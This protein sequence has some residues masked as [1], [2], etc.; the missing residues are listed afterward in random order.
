MLKIK[1]EDFGKDS[2]LLFE[3]RIY[4]HLEKEEDYILIL[5][6]RKIIQK[7]RERALDKFGVIGDLYLYTFEDLIERTNKQS[8]IGMYFVDIILKRSIEN[9]QNQKK[10][11]KESLY[12]SKGFLVICKQILSLL[13]NSNA[14]IKSLEKSIDL[15][16]LKTILKILAEYEL[17]MKKYNIPTPTELPYSIK[18]SVKNSRDIKSILPVFR[19]SDPL[20]WNGLKKHPAIPLRFP[21]REAAIFPL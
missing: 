21:F 11:E 4:D 9:L 5:P 14:D 7:I 12:L 3:N 6:N 8:E 19:N 10:I 18:A 17:Q 13:R 2:L 15:D 20:N 16:S 1:I